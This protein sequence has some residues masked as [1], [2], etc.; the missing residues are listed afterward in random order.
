MIVTD[1]RAVI[2]IGRF[3][4]TFGV[5]LSL[6]TVIGR[7]VVTR[8]LTIRVRYIDESH[9]LTRRKRTRGGVRGDRRLL[10]KGVHY[11]RGDPR[12][13]PTTKDTFIDS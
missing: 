12:E 4:K 1:E 11:R 10:T 13:A 5:T 8:L 6:P 9:E 2:P 7:G 3:H